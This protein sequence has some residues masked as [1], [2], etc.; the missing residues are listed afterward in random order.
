MSN[1]IS[2]LLVCPLTK[3]RLLPVGGRRLELLT[4]ALEK[5]DLRYVDGSPLTSDAGRIAF[6]ITDNGRHLYTVV[7]DVPVMLESRQVDIQSL[8]I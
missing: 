3:Q 4:A 8:D 1:R 7:D 2:P 5:G 6:L